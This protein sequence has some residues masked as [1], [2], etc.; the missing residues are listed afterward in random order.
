MDSREKNNHNHLHFNPYVTLG[1]GSQPND[2]KGREGYCESHLEGIT[3]HGGHG[4][5]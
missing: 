2:R 1:E 3:G 5:Q 4:R